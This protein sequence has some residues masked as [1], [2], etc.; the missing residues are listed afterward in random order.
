MLGIKQ[1]KEI[2]HKFTLDLDMLQDLN[3]LPLI[4]DSVWLGLFPDKYKTETIKKL[5]IKIKELMKTEA[6]LREDRELILK[7]KKKDINKIIEL[8]GSTDNNEMYIKDNMEFRRNTIL[9]ANSDVEE[10]SNNIEK[11]SNELKET[12]LLLLKESMEICY[13][14]MK[15]SKK[16]LNE[17]EINIEEL[18]EKLKKC[19]EDKAIYENDYEKTYK[20]MHRML[21][22]EIIEILDIRYNEL[23]KKNDSGNRN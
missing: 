20:L 16:R 6:R 5:E 19:I 10:L 23:E 8:M 11:V 14:V 18:R 7:M 12:N 22:K 21:G 13:N 17:L 9:K 4:L 3:I 1:K 15:D 2:N